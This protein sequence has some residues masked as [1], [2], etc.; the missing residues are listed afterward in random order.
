MRNV[1]KLS[2][3]L[4]FI[5]VTGFGQA[6]DIVINT[7]ITDQYGGTVKNL[8]IERFDG[9]NYIPID[10][11][12]KKLG[13]IEFTANATDSII[14]SAFK[15]SAI[16]T[17]AQDITTKDKL[18]IKRPF[19]FIDLV[20][21]QFYIFYGGLWLL[22]FIVFAETGLFLGFFLPGDSLLFIAGVYSQ[23]LAKS[24]FDTGSDF[25]NLL[26]VMILVIIAGILGNMLGY[27]MGDKSK[28]LF[29]NMKDTWYFKRKYLDEA[30]EFYVKYGGGAIF[31]ARFLPIVRTFAPIVAGIVKMD[32]S[33]FMFYN[34]VGCITWVVLLV[35][36][37]HYLDSYIR[38]TFHFELKDH[39]GLI[40]ISL[41]VITTFPVLWKLLKS[42]VAKRKSINLPKDETN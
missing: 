33:K 15:E 18:E 2:V 40:I 42:K 19:S 38:N 41:I 1:I 27:Y 36:G 29:Y 11:T 10:Y 3:I 22:L 7:K 13:H 25:G 39:L 6:A 20:N 16:R 8:K 24:L 17:T 21:P 32:K 23:N 28:K 26:I 12:N 5:L 35:A 37:G 30:H 14:I 31:L 9:Q 4:F 34:I